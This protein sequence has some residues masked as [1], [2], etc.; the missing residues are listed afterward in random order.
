MEFKKWLK[1]SEDV[2]GVL[3]PALDGIKELDLRFEDYPESTPEQ[4]FLKRSLRKHQPF[5]G[6]LPNRDTLSFDGKS[7]RIGGRIPPEAL[8]LPRDW[9]DYTAGYNGNHIVKYPKVTRGDWETDPKLLA[10]AVQ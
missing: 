1:L 3:T 2:Y 9:W 10:G 8:E 7:L 5:Y 4:T 6:T